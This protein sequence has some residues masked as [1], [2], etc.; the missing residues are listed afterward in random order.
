M[1]ILRYII[2]V[3]NC[4]L[5]NEFC[6]LCFQ[7]QSLCRVQWIRYYTKS[8]SHDEEYKCLFSL[9]QENLTKPLFTCYPMPWWA[10]I[11][12]FMRS[13]TVGQSPASISQ[14]RHNGQPTA[15]KCH[16]C[17]KHPIRSQQFERLSIYISVYI[18]AILIH[19]RQRFLSALLES[20]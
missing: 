10:I 1:T 19:D 18:P 8:A 13:A 11:L 17:H 3:S 2:I 5:Q 9:L 7:L 4:M 12:L 14:L 20:S 6:G 16:L 15:I